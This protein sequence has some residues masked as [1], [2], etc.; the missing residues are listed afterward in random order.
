MP[1]EVKV[2]IL[3]NGNAAASGRLEVEGRDVAIVWR[4]CLERWLTYVPD[5]LSHL[6]YEPAKDIELSY[7][8]L[9]LREL[10]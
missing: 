10:L 1:Y 6:S 5:S 2:S 4:D 9:E 3:G 8:D 7:R